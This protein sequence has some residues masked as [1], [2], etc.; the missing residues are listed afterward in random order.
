MAAFALDAPNPFRTRFSYLGINLLWTIGFASLATVL[1]IFGAVTGAPITSSIAIGCSLAVIL[2]RGV[3]RRSLGPRAPIVTAMSLLLL[4]PIL[5]IGGGIALDY[6]VVAMRLHCGTAL[7]MTLMGTPVLIFIALLVGRMFGTIVV[8]DR[9]RRWVDVALNGLAMLALVAG[10]VLLAVMTNHARKRTTPEKYMST[11]PV[12]AVIAPDAWTPAS[13]FPIDGMIATVDDQ[14]L[15]RRCH[16]ARCEVLLG[17]HPRVEYRN[18]HS[19]QGVSVSDKEPLIVR[20]DAAHG[21]YVLEQSGV[22]GAI[23]RRTNEQTEISL[24]MVASSIAP[25]RPWLIGLAVGTLVALF[26]LVRRRTV[27]GE[28]RSLE[29]AHA[30]R[31]T[32][33][34]ALALA[35]GVRWRAPDKFVADPDTEVA[36][37]VDAEA[38]ATFRH[39]GTPEKM[40]VQV[41]SRE[42]LE[43]RCRN[44]ATIWSAIAI[45][46]IALAA[47]PLL[48]ALQ[49]GL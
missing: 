39:D 41:G 32:E 44:E 13:E 28:L 36:I 35:E 17:A 22:V 37:L 23:D 16:E 24:R 8:G 10:V 26:A 19:A 48:A 14:P 7:M 31:V 27:R 18:G 33:H 42:Q 47:A 2:L 6:P 29:R 46:T 34:G 12:I 38:R 3:M 25:P 45:A 40:T 30:A 9:E 21:F 20:L 11:L 5:Y 1:L 49:L 43:R 4:V 15:T